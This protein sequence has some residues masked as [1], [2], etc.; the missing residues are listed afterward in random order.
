[1]IVQ[2]NNIQQDTNYNGII[3]ILGEFSNCL[4][5]SGVCIWENIIYR[6]IDHLQLRQGQLVNNANNDIISVLQHT[7]AV[8]R[9][10]CEGVTESYSNINVGGNRR[11]QL[12]YNNGQN[13]VDLSVKVRLEL[14][15]F[16][17]E[18]EL[19]IITELWIYEVV[20]NLGDLSELLQDR[21]NQVY[22]SKL[23]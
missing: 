21:I 5:L 10:F 9:Q 2:L 19:S 15:S 14:L 16:M 13:I 6:S 22:K 4:I 8:I 17:V 1:M 18:Y 11:D 23:Q 12:I 3:K 20:R 7:N